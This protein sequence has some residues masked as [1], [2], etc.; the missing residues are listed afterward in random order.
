MTQPNDEQVFIVSSEDLRDI[1]SRQQSKIQHLNSKARG[2]AGL[3]LTIVAI[4]FTLYSIFPGYFVKYQGISP[5]VRPS[6]QILGPVYGE[7][8][9][10]TQILLCFLILGAAV[11]FSITGFMRLIE[12]TLFSSTDLSKLPSPS[13]FG[14]KD[15]KLYELKLNT[16]SYESY[17]WEVVTN[18][19]KRIEILNHRYNVGVFRLLAGIIFGLFS[20]QTYSGLI[21]GD[22]DRLVITSALI[23]IPTPMVVILSQKVNLVQNQPEKLS[24]D[25]RVPTLFE[26]LTYD[27]AEFS[28]FSDVEFWLHER[29]L[30]GGSALMCLIT[31][32]LYLFSL[33]M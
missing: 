21:T 31:V 26:E 19:D 33:A 24:T 30:I 17:L 32:V 8:L 29:V 20:Y 27:E 5:A 1:A 18:T 14:I 22:I 11:S 23:V 12:V 15:I 6:V 28:R 10:A 13:I 25:H 4:V 3:A 7:G 9:A 2:T 16:E